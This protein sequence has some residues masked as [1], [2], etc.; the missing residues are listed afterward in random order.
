MASAAPVRRGKLPATRRPRPTRPTF[1]KRSQSSRPRR[2]NRLPPP[3][4]P[5]RLPPRLLQ[6]LPM[7]S[8]LPRSQRRPPAAHVRAVSVRPDPARSTLRQTAGC[9]ADSAAAADARA[10]HRS[11]CLADRNID[12]QEEV[13]RSSKPLIFLS[14]MFLSFSFLSAV[15]PAPAPRSA[16]AGFRFGQAIPARL[17]DPRSARSRPCSPRP[18]ATRPR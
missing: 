6:R 8:Q 2:A 10:K 1:R 3:R 16:R 15:L 13:V 4:L 5:T 18:R 7:W 11:G 14:F 9:G 12:G 17:P